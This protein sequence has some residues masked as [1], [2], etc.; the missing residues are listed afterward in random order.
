M[1]TLSEVKKLVA[2][3]DLIQAIQQDVQ[4]LEGT[5][6]GDIP[7]IFNSY[8]NLEFL[9]KEGEFQD[10]FNDPGSTASSSLQ[11]ILGDAETYLKG[12]HLTADIYT[13][14]GKEGIPLYSGE[15]EGTCTPVF[16]EVDSHGNPIPVS[17]WEV[18]TDPDETLIGDLGSLFPSYAPDSWEPGNFSQWLWA[19][20]A[21]GTHILLS[22]SDASALNQDALLA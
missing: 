8:S 5:Q 11:K 3:V 6:D 18:M 12:I 13:W 16:N 7:T 9:N 2:A 22:P 15:V 4:G 10:L 19:A 1:A 14:Q 20:H 21:L 17:L